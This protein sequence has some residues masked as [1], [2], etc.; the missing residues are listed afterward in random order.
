MSKTLSE[1]N[2]YLRD[3]EMRKKSLWISV[4]SSSAIEGIH[5]PF[6]KDAPLTVS[7]FSSTG[8]VVAKSGKPRR[9]K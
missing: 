9:G 1:T 2:P 7:Y 6:S 5:H 3:P 4:K 8:R